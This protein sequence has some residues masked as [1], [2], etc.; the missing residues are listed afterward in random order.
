MADT[1]DYLALIQKLTDQLNAM[2]A[3]VPILTDP[4]P[5]ADLRKLTNAAAVPDEFIQ[6]LAA[7]AANPAIPPGAIGVDVQ[8]MLDQRRA[9]AAFVL[10][11]S[12][13]RNFAD[14]LHVAMTV[15]RHES[16][17]SALVAYAALQNLQRLPGGQNLV[18][19]VRELRTLLGRGPVKRRKADPAPTEP[20][21][22]SDPQTS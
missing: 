17:R 4:G 13:A 22:G 1:I 14:N 12:Q 19:P 3:E 10:L 9:T 20:P 15:V 8:Q 18:S 7:A 2:R 6:R 21:A 16:G 11:E 5:K